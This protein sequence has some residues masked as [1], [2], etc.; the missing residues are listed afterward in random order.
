MIRNANFCLDF[1]LSYERVSRN[2]FL[3]LTFTFLSA[4]A[5]RQGR[6]LCRALPCTAAVDAFLRT[7]IFVYLRKKH[8]L[9]HW[10]FAV[11]YS[12]F[13]SRTWLLADVPFVLVFIEH[14]NAGQPLFPTVHCV[15]ELKVNAGVYHYVKKPFHSKFL[16][17]CMYFPNV[18]MFCVCIFSGEIARESAIWGKLEVANR[19]VDVSSIAVGAEKYTVFCLTFSTQEAIQRDLLTFCIVFLKVQ[20]VF[21]NYLSLF[22]YPLNCAP[23]GGHFCG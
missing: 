20:E 1:H 7:C 15:L 23:E 3:L 13:H 17:V 21:S 18:L 4:C 9:C 10:S 14:Y 2:M 19:P 16:K 5:S 12:V 6:P 22:E 8:S 11:L